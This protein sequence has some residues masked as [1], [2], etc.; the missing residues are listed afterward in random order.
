MKSGFVTS[1]SALRFLW[2]AA[3]TGARILGMN[4]HSPIPFSQ[5]TAW[6]RA[7]NRLAEA[8]ARRLASGQPSVDLTESNPTR[9]GFSYPEARILRALADPRGLVYEPLPRG[10]PAAREAVAAHLAAEVPGAAPCS[11]E[12]LVLCA[13][14]S[15]AYS[16]LMKLL[17]ERGDQVLVPHPSYPLF[18]FLAGLEDVTLVRYALRREERWRIDFESLAATP[19]TRAIIVVHP[20]NPTGNTLTVAEAGELVDFCAER[21]LAIISDEV[22]LE[23]AF[24]PTHRAAS[25]PPIEETAAEAS[26][27]SS[28][29]AGANPADSSTPRAARRD[30][31]DAGHH[32]RA[33]SLA[34]RGG[35]LV[36]SLGG[37]SKSSG[38]PQIKVGWIRVGGPPELVSEA[39]ARLEVIADTYLSVNTP[40]QWALPELLAAGREVRNAIRARTAANRRWLA[41]RARNVAWELLPAD[42]GWYAVLRVPHTRTEEEWC[43]LFAEE[44]GVLLHP[45]F[46]F[47]FES[48][49]FLVASLLP[50]EGRFAEAMARVLGRIGGTEEAGERARHRGRP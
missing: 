18:D 38:L 44:E 43:L 10:L 46:F 11:P 48:E 2:R 32:L 20:N 28:D 9:C 13:S 29:H 27:D 16:W 22:F 7:P 36:F 49:A 5:R 6:E 47:D 19:R 42:G 1:G 39:L 33:G 31:P 40:A 25:S 23:Y 17:C 45:G 14:T 26:A 41:S 24:P 12:D 3:R 37:L 30:S 8:W 15:E 50:E 4:R 21:N 34:R 35:C